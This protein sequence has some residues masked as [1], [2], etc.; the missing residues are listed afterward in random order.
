MEKLTYILSISGSDSTGSSGIQADIRTIRDLGAHAVTAITSVTVQ[1]SSGIVS[2]DEMPAAVVAGQIRAVYEEC[3]PRAVKVGMVNSPDSIHQLRDQIIGCR[4]IVVSPVILSSGGTRLMSEAS[5][6]AFRRRLL[7]AAQVLVMRASD[8]ELM[9]GI[10]IRTDEELVRAA[11]TLRS[12]GAE[13]V[14]LRGSHHVEQRLTALLCGPECCRFFSSHNVEGWQR[15]GVGGVLST[16]IAT[17]LALGDTVVDAVLKAHHYLHSQIVYTVEGDGRSLRPAELY[18]QYHT[19]IAEHYRQHHD[20]A[21][22]ASN[23]NITPRYL[24]QITRAACA[25][26]PKQILDEYLLKESVAL[27]TTTT[28]SVQEVAYRLG[29]SS[30]VL[31]ARFLRS[32]GGKNAREVR[33]L[34]NAGID[35]H[36]TTL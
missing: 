6:E 7:P 23:L 1:N 30:Q 3:R 25:K 33:N 14:M 4:H 24:S 17:R 2:I 8:V 32:R 20:V 26:T 5:V 10:Q 13:W 34:H 31:F 16:A 15:H 9:L 11:E 18:N 12:E 35:G 19:L 28:L 27:L 22:Y 36:M 21:F 29:F